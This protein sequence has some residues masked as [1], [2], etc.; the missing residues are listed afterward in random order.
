M[1]SRSPGLFSKG[2]LESVDFL[3]DYALSLQHLGDLH[4]VFG[5]PVHAAAFHL[6]AMPHLL[7]VRRLSGDEPE[8]LKGLCIAHNNLA[9]ARLRAADPKAALQVLAEFEELVPDAALRLPSSVEGHRAV[10]ESYCLSGQAHLGLHSTD[11]AWTRLLEASRLAD[12]QAAEGD[13]AVIWSLLR[14]ETLNARAAC[15]LLRGDTDGAVED[16]AVAQSLLGTI[17]ASGGKGAHANWIRIENLLTQQSARGFSPVFRDSPDSIDHRLS[18][19]EVELRK[20]GSSRPECAMAVT[21]R[22]GE[23]R[24]RT[25]QWFTNPAP[26]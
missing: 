18:S 10:V 13:A 6:D 3:R 1:L 4:M 25:A 22:L 2:N 14:A 9:R 24:A 5:Q 17:A 19:L 7:K 23:I 11:V 8:T 26:R 15:R 20:F 12:T 21:E 16:W